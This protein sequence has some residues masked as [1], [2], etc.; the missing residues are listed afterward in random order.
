MTNVL[1]WLFCD[2][3]GI[4]AG[5]ILYYDMGGVLSWDNLAFNGFAWGD[6]M[7]LLVVV[8]SRGVLC[9]FKWVHS[10]RGGPYH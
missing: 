6:K 5:C 8:R 3:M 4:V 2:C 10:I 9:S 1:A 7:Y